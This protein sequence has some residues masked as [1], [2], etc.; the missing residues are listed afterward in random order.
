MLF[1]A[2]GITANWEP[3]CAPDL[4]S[5]NFNAP[6]LFLCPGHADIG[7]AGGQQCLHVDDGKGAEAYIS[8]NSFGYVG[9][10]DK[11]FTLVHDENAGTLGTLENENVFSQHL[12]ECLCC[13]SRSLWPASDCGSPTTH[14]S[15]FC[16]SM[17]SAAAGNSARKR[18]CRAGLPFHA[19]RCSHCFVQ[20]S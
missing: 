2:A 9:P 16:A 3:V 18:K 10:N 7:W 20:V 4:S 14:T 13:R 8:A 6:W 1:S 17:T 12:H 5:N 15:H 19:E 11:G